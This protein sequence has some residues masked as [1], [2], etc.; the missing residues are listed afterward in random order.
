MRQVVVGKIKVHRFPLLVVPSW[1]TIGKGRREI[2][3]DC[4]HI[5]RIGRRLLCAE[6]KERRKWGRARGLKDD[7]YSSC[8]FMFT[9]ETMLP[10]HQAHA[11]RRDPSGPLPL[12]LPA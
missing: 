8:I 4:V 10:P 11:L 12:P 2:D 7:S 5:A 1:G 9:Y 6:V 3:K